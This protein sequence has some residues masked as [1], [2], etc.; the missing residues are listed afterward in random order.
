[1]YEPVD[2]APGLTA[3]GLRHSMRRLAFVLLALSVACDWT[4]P[5][6]P[7]PDLT[8]AYTLVS[9][10]VDGLTETPPRVRAA[11]WLSSGRHLPPGL[12]LA[13]RIVWRRGDST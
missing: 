13:A 5:S 4:A 1:M 12:P 8:G 7:P 3:P 11:L 2:P 9:Y 10:T 6:E